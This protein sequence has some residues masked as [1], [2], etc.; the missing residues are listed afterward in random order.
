FGD[1]FGDGSGGAGED[2]PATVESPDFR[3][4]VIPDGVVGDADAVRGAALGFRHS[5]EIGQAGGE[6]RVRV[7]RVFGIDADRVPDVTETGDATKCG[8][9]LAA[10]P[11][12]R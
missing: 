2:P 11:D 1:V 10:D 4:L 12:R 6:L 8:H 5:A 7:E 3:R 9:A